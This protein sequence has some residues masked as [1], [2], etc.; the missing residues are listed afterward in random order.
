VEARLGRE[1]LVNLSDPDV[2][3]RA[4]VLGPVTLVGIVRKAWRT[5]PAAGGVPS[6]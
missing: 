1:P 5:E 6:P 3:I 2:V 4:E